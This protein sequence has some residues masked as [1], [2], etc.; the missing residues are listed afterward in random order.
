MILFVWSLII[1]LVLGMWG[2][3]AFLPWYDRIIRRTNK[4][5]FVGERVKLDGV[6]YRVVR[7]KDSTTQYAP[8]FKERYA[9][10]FLR[11]LGD[12]EATVWEVMKS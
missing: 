5:S 7:V 11:R 3:L 9:T 8:L 6:W 2:F 4:Y 12:D 10:V 1:L